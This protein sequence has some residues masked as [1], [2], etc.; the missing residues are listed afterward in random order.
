MSWLRTGLTVMVIC[1]LAAPYGMAQKTDPAPKSDT[2]TS[3]EVLAT[4]NGEPLTQLDYDQ[5]LQQYR[6]EARAQAQQ[7]KGRFMR[8]LV[9][10]ELLAQE[11]KRLKVEDDPALQS[12]LKIQRNGAIARAV[13]Q[14]YI[15]E[16]GNVTDERLRSHYDKNKA[17]YT[18][19]EQVSASHILVKTEDEAKE[20]H[21]EIK[22]GKDFAELAKAKSTGPSGPR[23]GELGTFGRGR[24]VP[25]FEKAAFALKVGEVSEPV[26]TQ[27]GYHVIKV[28]KRTEAAPKT[29]EAVQEDIRRTLTSEYV[30]SLL[31]D[32]QGKAKVE[33]KNPEYAIQEK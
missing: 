23:G 12:R 4:V 9:L 25:E 6:P 18:E 27:F 7:N 15:Q 3:K 5:L 1:L 19:D 14:K 10:Q 30:E 13:V 26:K 28:T 2:D 20:V 11:G 29:F 31:K 16:E 22:A 32:L 24:M 8:E 33:V 21:K 17:S